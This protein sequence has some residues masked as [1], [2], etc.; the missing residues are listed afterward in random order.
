MVHS[1]I[2]SS[3]IHKKILNIFRI[4]LSH[5]Y[6]MSGIIPFLRSACLP[7][8]V[9]FGAV[10][11]NLAFALLAAFR[12]N[13]KNDML[14]KVFV[15]LLVMTVLIGLAFTW[16]ANWLCVQGLSTVAWLVVLLPLSTLLLNIKLLL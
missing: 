16:F 11:V 8:Q 2:P 14:V 15:S 6:I 5:I 9:Y 13:K 10:L 4:F 3:F 7:A 12:K 1:F